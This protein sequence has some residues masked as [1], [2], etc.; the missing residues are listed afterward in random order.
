MRPREEELR[1]DRTRLEQDD[2]T[3]RSMEK[4]EAIVILISKSDDKFKDK[5]ELT[6]LYAHWNSLKENLYINN[7]PDALKNLANLAQVAEAIYKK[8]KTLLSPIANALNNVV[9][10][11]DS[12][13]RDPAGLAKNLR[14][15]ATKVENGINRRNIQKLSSS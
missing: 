4:L 9:S 7:Q 8:E 11:K 14:D 3:F 13:P 15:T 6:K 1:F 10:N 2:I 5:D 12:I